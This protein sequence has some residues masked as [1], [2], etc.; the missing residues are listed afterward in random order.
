MVAFVLPSGRGILGEYEDSFRYE[1]E[2]QFCYRIYTIL[3]EVS[4]NA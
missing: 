2:W 3:G 4:E 1:R